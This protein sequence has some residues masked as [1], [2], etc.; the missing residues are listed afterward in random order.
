MAVY[1]IRWSPVQ[2]PDQERLAR[3]SKGAAQAALDLVDA[4]G[5]PW[6]GPE[7]DA[8]V[9]AIQ[10]WALHAPPKP[11]LTLEWYHAI[12]NVGVFTIRAD[13]GNGHPAAPRYR[14]NRHHR[15]WR[16]K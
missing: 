7:R 5:G 10:S 4:I 14:P 1:T 13:H 12:A 8:L 2:G 16:K 11:H 6:E 15:M 9:K 3:N